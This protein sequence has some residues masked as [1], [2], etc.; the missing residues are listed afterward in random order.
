M[1]EDR[2]ERTG[3]VGV[4]KYTS[5]KRLHRGKPDICWYILY[6]DVAGK[7]I[8]EK[9]GWLSEGYTMAR[10]QQ[11]RAERTVAV[12]KGEPVKRKTAPLF[13]EVAEK[14]LEWAA[15]NKARGAIDDKSR[16]AKHLAP[17][18]SEKRL[19][20]I[21]A[22]DLEAMKTELSER[23]APATVA[24]ILKL[25]RMIWNRAVDWDLWRGE[26]PTRKVKMPV[27]RNTR[28]RF[29][30]HQEAAVLLEELKKRS[31]TVHDYAAVSLYTGMRAGELFA[32]RGHDVDLKHGVITITDPK[33][34]SRRAVFMT[35]IVKQIL[36]AR[37]PKD[38]GDHIFKDQRHGGRITEVS[39]TFR[40]VA[41]V[42]FNVGV[43]DRRQRVTFHSL[44]HTHASWLALQGESLLVIKEALGH[45]DLKMTQRYA[46]LAD[47]ARRRAAERLEKD[48][49]KHTHPPTKRES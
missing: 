26:S 10:A 13:G 25:F 49:Q 7:V 37:M 29:L 2:R 43:N 27:P 46:H 3:M 12:A 38:P 21:T 4:Y 47:E 33:N 44:R 17:R 36:A 20:Q 1:G 39:E 19:D 5:N 45:K 34:K 48:F 15:K 31:V 24:H 32:L 41:D 11:I 9:I 30:S 6:R 28:E 8:R 18:F 16:Y 23:Y 22:L 35:A 14:Y 42:L 40:L